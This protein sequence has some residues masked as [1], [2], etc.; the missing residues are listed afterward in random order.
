MV[1]G[2]IKPVYL[3]NYQE[4][5]EGKGRAAA[6]IDMEMT[7]AKSMVIKA[8]DNDKLDGR[9]LKAFRSVKRKLKKG[10]NA[11]KRTLTL[12]RRL[13]SIDI[14]IFSFFPMRKICDMVFSLYPFYQV[15]CFRDA[16]IF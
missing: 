2:D 13:L 9:V 4:D 15:N 3:E 10:S 16:E 14:F 11:R 7:I 6:T 5:R 12:Q 8:F 1:A